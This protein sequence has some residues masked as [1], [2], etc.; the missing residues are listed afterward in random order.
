MLSPAFSNFALTATLA[1]LPGFAIDTGKLPEHRPALAVVN[2]ETAISSSSN[3][4]AQFEISVRN[5]SN[6]E[7]RIAAFYT[8]FAASQETLGPE[9]EALLLNNL[10]SLYED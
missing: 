1:T 6:I 5:N 7:D 8:S 10:A 9:L 3:Q 4:S 2:F